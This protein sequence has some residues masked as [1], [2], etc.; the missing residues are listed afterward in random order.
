MSG[1]T[2]RSYNFP[3][4]FFRVEI[5][6]LNL[7]PRLVYFLGGFVQHFYSWTEKH[8]PFGLDFLLERRCLTTA[9]CLE[10]NTYTLLENKLWTIV[11]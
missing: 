2:Q 9:R 11:L 6:P 7:L 5:V 3:T 1:T 8:L 4:P 10:P